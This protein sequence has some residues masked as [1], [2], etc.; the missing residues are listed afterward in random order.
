MKNKYLDFEDLIT[1]PCYAMFLYIGE[2]FIIEIPCQDYWQHSSGPPQ[3]CQGHTP[4]RG[5]SWCWSLSP[6]CSRAPP[7]QPAIEYQ[8]SVA[9]G[10]PTLPTALSRPLQ[11]KTEN[12]AFII[13]FEFANGWVWLWEFFD[14]HRLGKNKLNPGFPNAL[15]KSLK[16]ML[17]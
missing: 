6:P 7:A 4:C 2:C 14:L 17:P 11:P 1:E 13:P 5:R 8:P 9:A 16:Y 12:L 15:N 3:H 10:T